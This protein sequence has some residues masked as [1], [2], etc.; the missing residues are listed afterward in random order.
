MPGMT[1]TYAPSACC[2]GGN[3]LRSLRE[4]NR[5]LEQRLAVFE[6]NT[7]CGGDCDT[8][9]V[10]FTTPGITHTTGQITLTWKS[11]P[12]M[13][14]QVESSPDGETWTVITSDLTAGSGETTTLT[15]GLPNG[16]PVVYYRVREAP[17]D[18][19]CEEE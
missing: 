3:Q 7:T 10:N 17:V 12:L 2:G 18:N 4:H 6:Q 5:K 15:I 11:N 16:A 8:C 19:E 9:C 1:G 14:F 13:E